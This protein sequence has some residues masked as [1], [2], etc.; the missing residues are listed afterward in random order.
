MAAP[1]G[2]PAPRRCVVSVDLDT[3]DCYYRIH[4]LTP[5]RFARDPILLEGVPRFV[6]LLAPRAIPATFFAIGATAAT[7]FARA[8]FPA[9]VRAGHEIANHSQTHPYDLFRRSRE[10]ITDE[11]RRAHDGLAEAAGRAPVGFRAPGYGLSPR[12]LAALVAQG[13]AYDSSVLPSPPYYAAKAAIMGAMAVTGHASRSA[14]A[15]PR[16]AL[17]PRRPY[18]PHLCRPWRRGDAPL[19][20]VPVTVLPGLRVPLVGMTLVTAPVLLRRGLLAVLGRLRLVVLNLH[21]IDL[22]DAERD[23]LPAE[24]RDKQP[25]LR[26]PLGHKRVALARTLD[27]LTR[28]GFEFVTLARLAA[29]VAAGQA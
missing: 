25:D 15:D 7:E 22:V 2:G 23:G 27:A 1:S 4:G 16:L 6:E 9:L 5:P 13:Y 20:E 10:E 28:A 19:V 14:L 17:A 12:L 26:V 11:V 8:A 21:G 29:E 18:R 24:L 3:I